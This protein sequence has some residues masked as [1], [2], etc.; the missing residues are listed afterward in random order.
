MATVLCMELWDMDHFLKEYIP[1]VLIPRTQTM[2][3]F[4]SFGVI[5]TNIILEPLRKAMQHHSIDPHIT[6]QDLAKL[7]GKRLVIT[8]SD[9]QTHQPT[10]FSLDTTPHVEILT[11]VAASCAVP[12]VFQPVPIH[13]RLYVDGCLTDNHPIESCLEWDTVS[14]NDQL[15]TI[16]V[17]TPLLPKNDKSNSSSFLEYIT[18]LV[19]FMIRTPSTTKKEQNPPLSSIVFTQPVLPLLPF[20]FDGDG[21]RL[22]ITE[23][24]I[25]D[26]I[27]Q[28]LE[29]AHQWFM[30]RQV[31]TP[32]QEGP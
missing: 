8:A 11:A 5:S 6:F 27:V 7:T 29:A 31:Q 10:Y 12:L 9:T 30:Q 17:N 19:G 18:Q 22:A 32:S 16:S 4:Q 24:Q 21:I 3:L 25:D 28:G 23:R 2:N 13:E 1:S 26:A 14:R 15:L 20:S